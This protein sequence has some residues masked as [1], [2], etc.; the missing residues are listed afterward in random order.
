M[1]YFTSVLRDRGALLA[2]TPKMA[3]YP[4][5]PDVPVDTTENDNHQAATPLGG[6]HVMDTMDTT[7]DD[8]RIKQEPV[9]DKD[10]IFLSPGSP[11]R[12][13]YTMAAPNVAIP[14]ILADNGEPS[15]TACFNG[16]F[17]ITRTTTCCDADT[18]SSPP[19]RSLARKTARPVRAKASLQVAA[20]LAQIQNAGARQRRGQTLQGREDE[21]SHH[22]YEPRLR[23]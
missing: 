2:P 23:R 15:P 21:L 11:Q 16:M 9:E 20:S 17:F 1:N 14:R 8:V 6:L 13:S 22:N 7:D 5:S 12:E 4:S 19:S 10:T 3:S 18:T